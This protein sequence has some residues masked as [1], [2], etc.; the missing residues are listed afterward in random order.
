MASKMPGDFDWKALT[1]D[2][3]PLTPPDLMKDPKTQAR[4]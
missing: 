2:D 4:S 1:P 3:S